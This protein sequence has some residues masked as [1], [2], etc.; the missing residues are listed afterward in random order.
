MISAG[1]T[2]TEIF[3]L[4]PGREFHKINKNSYKQHG[5]KIIIKTHYCRSDLQTSLL[6]TK[7]WICSI[8]LW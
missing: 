6:V 3:R 5:D 4:L 7:V 2:F 8:F 1:V